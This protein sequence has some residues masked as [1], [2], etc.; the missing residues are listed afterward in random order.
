MVKREGTTPQDALRNWQPLC[1]ESYLA[2][3]VKVLEALELKLR[4]PLRLQDGPL[5]SMEPATSSLELSIGR[6]SGAVSTTPNH[7][8]SPLPDF[9][10]FSVFH[11]SGRA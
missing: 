7:E 11:V 6:V 1:K 10:S 8:S 2:G 5:R 4:Q 3:L 9:S